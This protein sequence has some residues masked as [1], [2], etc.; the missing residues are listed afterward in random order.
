MRNA[1]FPIG[2][3]P[4]QANKFETYIVN[5]ERVNFNDVDSVKAYT[6]R[7]LRS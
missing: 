3:V 4:S 6:N 5:V 1:F 7:L 2:M